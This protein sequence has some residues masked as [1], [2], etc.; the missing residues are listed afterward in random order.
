MPA[1]AIQ[2]RATLT[3]EYLCGV[4]ERA[5]LITGDQRREA[6]TKADGV[7]ARLLRQRA[8]GP[9]KRAAGVGDGV[10][11]AEVI[12]AMG[13]GQGGDPRFPL[14]ERVIMQALAQHVRLPF[15]DL[16]PLKIDAKLAPQLLSRPFARRHGALIIAADDRTVTV[17]VADPLDHALVEALQSH[18]RREPSLVVSTPTDIQRL[19]TDFYGFRGAVD[20]AELQAT[21]GVDIGN[22]ERYV[23]LNRVEEIEASD[24][25]VVAA[26]EY[27]LHYAL[28]Q[29]ASD[30][31]IEPRRE[32]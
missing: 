1:T 20:A 14:S 17:A 4:L 28:D 2:A 31:H 6:A 25:H 15:V 19:I 27:L 26:V 22:L 32:H 24:S 11:P 9:R 13:L 12:V 18:V 21:G 3:F 23:K 7:Q 8:T 5:S 10:H 16:D 30:V 29:R